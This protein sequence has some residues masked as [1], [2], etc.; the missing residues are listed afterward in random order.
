MHIIMANVTFKRN[1]KKIKKSSLKISYNSLE[2]K[3][4]L[5]VNELKK[6]IKS[7]MSFIKM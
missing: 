4:K 3:D 5:N 2:N 7:L 6:L 1:I